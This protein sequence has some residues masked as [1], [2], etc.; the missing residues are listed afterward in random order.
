MYLF[1]CFLYY[2]LYFRSLMKRYVIGDIHG[3][4]KA[5][6]QCL[7]RSGFRRDIDQLIVLGDICDGWDEVY[8]CVEELLTIRNRIDLL[9]NHDEWFRRFLTTSMH[10]DCWI[11]GGSAT[12][13]S[14]LR[15]IDREEY[16]NGNKYSGYSTF[17]QPTDIPVTHW[18]FFMS[19]QLAYVEDGRNDCFVHGGF[20][21]WKSMADN[22]SDGESLF[23]W[24]RDLWKAALSCR[25]TKLKTVDDFDRIFIG[26]TSCARLRDY[27]PVASG[28][29]INLDTG[30]GWEG[31]LTI[32]NVDTLRYW[33]SD[34]VRELY[35]YQAARR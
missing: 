30:A 3:A 35:P 26:H 6:V 1:Y 14:Y 29:V 2:I 13:I 11:Q 19:M 8:E 23:Y 9:G 20:D 18:K 21:R 16:L 24:D 10:P 25:G 12:A 28:G 32:M 22:R 5:L 17:L 4:H 34:G 33:Q 7:E 15:H 31:K 27:L